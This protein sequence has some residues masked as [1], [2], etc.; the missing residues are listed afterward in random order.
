ML[1]KPDQ[2]TSSEDQVDT[3]MIAYT[4]RQVNENLAA[5]VP[6]GLQPIFDD[7]EREPAWLLDS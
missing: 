2:M 3:T 7:I 5:R 6:A 1:K 4:T